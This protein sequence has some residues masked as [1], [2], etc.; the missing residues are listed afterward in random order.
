MNNIK[1]SFPSGYQVNDLMNDNID[2]H[3]ILE[4]E[5]YFL[6]LFTIENIRYLMDNES[7]TELNLYFSASNMVIIADLELS[8]ILRVIK[9]MY[10]KGLFLNDT[11]K[12]GDYDSIYGI[13]S[14]EDEFIAVP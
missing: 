12:I 7:D 5:V 1:I 8:T 9:D 11:F 14:K 10:V 2:L 6:T 13:S 3:V 4:R